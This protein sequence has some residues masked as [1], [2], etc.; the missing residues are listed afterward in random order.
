MYEVSTS[1]RRST[2]FKNVDGNPLRDRCRLVADQSQPLQSG[3]SNLRFQ[4]LNS[5]CASQHYQHESKAPSRS[6]AVR[7]SLASERRYVIADEL[8]TMP[9]KRAWDQV[10]NATDSAQPASRP[11]IIDANVETSVPIVS[12]KVKACASCRKQKVRICDIEVDTIE[13]NKDVDQMYHERQ[14]AAL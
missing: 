13:H 3:S 10:E 9:P 12:R 11:R 2:L 7:V 8:R 14:W 6:A 4:I 1:P 5:A